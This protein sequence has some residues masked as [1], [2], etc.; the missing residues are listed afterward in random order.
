MALGAAPTSSIKGMPAVTRAAK[1][2]TSGATPGR[3]NHQNHGPE[4]GNL[5]EMMMPELRRQQREKRD[6]K[7][8]ARKGQDTVQGKGHPH[9][10]MPAAPRGTSSRGQ[11]QARQ[12]SGE[13]CND[14]L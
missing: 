4:G 2:I 11:G 9:V 8:H 7:E 6:G 1:T 12:S 13:G 10:G 14:G 5:A 3:G